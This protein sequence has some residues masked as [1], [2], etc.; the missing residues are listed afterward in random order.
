MDGLI[1]IDVAS[2]RAQIQELG[3]IGYNA[4]KSLDEAGRT[5]FEDLS[6]KWASPNAVAFCDTY[7][8]SLELAF[9]AF[10]E[11]FY[12]VVHGANDAG[13]TLAKVHGDLWVD[14]GF[15]GEGVGSSSVGYCCCKENINGISGMAVEN[16]KTICYSFRAAIQ[17][18]VASV[19]YLP[20]SIQFVSPD[21]SLVSEYAIN[22]KS[23][24][25]EMGET[26]DPLSSAIWTY[27]ETETDNILLAKNEAENILKSNA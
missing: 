12:H 17:N 19:Y 21:G 3:E 6:T 7:A 9:N 15:P 20:T 26:L 11:K 27:I 18:A 10:R 24:V 16:V 22:I 1:G 8:R 23:I 5:F 14:V 2:A 4:Y 25:D 13:R